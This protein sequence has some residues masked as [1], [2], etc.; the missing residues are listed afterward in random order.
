MPNLR[1]NINK[2]TFKW[3]QI[4]WLKDIVNAY[5]DLTK[6][7]YESCTFALAQYKQMAAARA[8]ATSTDEWEI[9]YTV[10]EKTAI[11]YL[12]KDA[13]MLDLAVSRA[14]NIL[15]EIENLKNNYKE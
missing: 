5:I 11:E 12:S 6:R 7:S 10:E 4:D 9:S 14:L 2:I 13:E 3:D 1:N 15:D 8:N